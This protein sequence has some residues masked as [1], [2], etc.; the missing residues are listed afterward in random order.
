MYWQR[1]NSLCMLSDEDSELHAPVEPLYREV[2][3]G[4]NHLLEETWCPHL[5]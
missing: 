4:Y 5:P 3:V 1:P 2:G